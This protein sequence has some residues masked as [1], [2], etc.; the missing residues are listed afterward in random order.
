MTGFKTAA[1]VQVSGMEI[2]NLTE[3]PG[4]ISQ[5]LLEHWKAYQIF[6]S[7]ILPPNIT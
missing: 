3:A 4:L 7:G 5:A 1:V 2:C 6:N